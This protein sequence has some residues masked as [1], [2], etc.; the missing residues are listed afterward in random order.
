MNAPINLDDMAVRLPPHHAESEQAVLGG[1]LMDNTAIDRIDLAESDFY[2]HAHRLIWRSITGLIDACNP[3]DVITVAEVLDAAG[4]LD[5]VGGLA[6]IVALSSQTPS[7]ANIRSYA[8]TVKDRAML[9]RLAEAGMRITDMAYA[10]GDASA[11]VAD[12]QQAVMELDTTE[13]GQE[14][15]TLKDAL[16]AMVERIDRVSNGT[17]KATKTGFTD[18]DRKIIGL[19]SG[20]MVVVAGRPSMGKTAFAMQIATHVS[21][22]APVQIFSLEMGSEQLAMRMAAAE[23]KIDMMR[24]RSGNLH[25]ED[26]TRLT[27]ALERLHK[28]PIYIDDRAGLTVSQI[29]ARAR[30]TKRKNG[31]G[32]VVV[33]YIG[34]IHGEGNNRVEVVSEIS[35]GMKAMARELGV[36]VIALSQLSRKV[37]ERGDKRPMMSDLR[38]SGS[39]E[40]DADVILLLYRDEYYNTDTRWK[41][42]A[43]CNVAKQRNG[44]TGMVPLTFLA[45]HAQFGD[46]AGSYDPTPEKPSRRGF[47]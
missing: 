22:L 2:A 5:R 8:K 41:G 1:L 3:A 27:Y 20:D 38:E 9:R 17:E 30:Q 35:R 10:N 21:E 6:Y 16:R 7:A 45:D 32:L 42:V 31:L 23:A 15:I 13:A 18:I 28:R 34:L 26:W 4:E 44:P 12:A 40:Q 29:R 47:E 14:S 25:D 37:E 24:L 36:P 39:I 33:D 19:G 43:E 11:A 46:F